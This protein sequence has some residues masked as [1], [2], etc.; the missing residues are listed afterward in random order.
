MENWRTISHI[1]LH[2]IAAQM[3]LPETQLAALLTPKGNE[4]EGTHYPRR[5]FS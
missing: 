4:Y 5:P 3:N 1:G 2:N